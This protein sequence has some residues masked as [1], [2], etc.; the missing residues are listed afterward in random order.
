[1]VVRGVTIALACGGL[2]ALSLWLGCA[3]PRW[4]QAIERGR[5]SAVESTDARVVRLNA[6]QATVKQCRS[7][8]SPKEIIGQYERVATRALRGRPRPRIFVQHLLDGRSVLSYRDAD[9]QYVSVVANPDPSGGASY[10]VTRGAAQLWSLEDGRD[11]AGSDV[12]DVPRPPDSWR[13][14]C[15]ENPSGSGRAM[16]LYQGHNA[17]DATRRFYLRR[18]P[19]FGWQ[20]DLA[21][22]QHLSEADVS[23][24]VE[25]AGDYMVFKKG[26]RTC[27]ISMARRAAGAIATTI[28]VR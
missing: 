21:M 22:A 10:T 12:P 11:G 20:L 1:M 4:W 9:G 5:S 15:L 16:L 2:L 26:R 14:F 18:M 7:P 23:S 13:V 6:E 19:E 3:G 27:I 17:A 8:L 28:L 25:V 24:D